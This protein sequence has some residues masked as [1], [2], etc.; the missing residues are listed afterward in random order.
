MEIVEVGGLAIALVMAIIAI[1][2]SQNA[3]KR[4]EEEAKFRKEELK[5]LRLRIEELV[6]KIKEQ[7]GEGIQRPTPSET[8]EINHQTAMWQMVE[9][10]KK[11]FALLEERHSR[12]L[13]RA[14]SDWDNHSLVMGKQERQWEN[15]FKD[16]RVMQKKH[17]FMIQTSEW[18]NKRD[19]KQCP[20]FRFDGETVSIT[21]WDFSELRKEDVE[22]LNETAREVRGVLRTV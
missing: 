16:F 19:P 2:N 6:Q 1:L 12:L 3:N 22:L 11:Y 21:V 10:E 8:E 5:L 9:K 4:T 17:G 7:K 14:D 18:M 15:W 13:Q 20:Q